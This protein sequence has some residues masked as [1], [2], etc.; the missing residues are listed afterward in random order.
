MK[1]F[2]VHTW[3]NMIAKH[4]MVIYDRKVLQKFL[5]SCFLALSQIFSSAKIF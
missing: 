4:S 1:F 5:Q 3:K 2:N